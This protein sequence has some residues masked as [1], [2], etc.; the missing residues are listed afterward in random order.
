MIL[1]EKIKI[2]AFS[3]D[4]RGILP[5]ESEDP[6]GVY[7]ITPQ[8]A[9]RLARRLAPILSTTSCASHSAIHPRLTP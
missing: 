7:L 8:R 9:G 6:P 1:D 4:E 3:F 2:T 5:G